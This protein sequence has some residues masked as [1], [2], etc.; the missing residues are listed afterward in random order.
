MGKY[1]DNFSLKILNQQEPRMDTNGY[2]FFNH[3]THETHQN[4]SPPGRQ[5]AEGFVWIKWILIARK[6][7]GSGGCGGC[8]RFA[9]RKGCHSEARGHGCKKGEKRWRSNF[10]LE[11]GWLLEVKFL[12]SSK[13]AMAL[14]LRGLTRDARRETR[15]EQKTRD[16]QTWDELSYCLT[17]PVSARLMSLV[18]RLMSLFATNCKLLV[19]VTKLC[20]ERLNK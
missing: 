15:D 11:N 17:S 1:N 19:T 4:A 12:N 18:S 13:G 9:W 16:G 7:N 6:A 3:K 10:K 14:P 2:E 8:H 5:S 20:T